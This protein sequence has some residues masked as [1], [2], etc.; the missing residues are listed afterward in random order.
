MSIT[1]STI[2]ACGRCGNNSRSI[3][4]LSGALIR[5]SPSIVSKADDL[6]TRLCPTR[7]SGG[8]RLPSHQ[9]NR[10]PKS[11]SY[12]K[13][14]T[15]RSTNPVYGQWQNVFHPRDMPALEWFGSRRQSTYPTNFILPLRAPWLHPTSPAPPRRARSPL[16]ENSRCSLQP[17]PSRSGW[18]GCAKDS[19]VPQLREGT[20]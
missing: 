20:A 15:S 12:M 10:R 2:G 5:N 4:T 16:Q 17:W 9:P 6:G 1:A 8:R 3:L 13:L 19:C 18:R 7:P 14:S 11:T